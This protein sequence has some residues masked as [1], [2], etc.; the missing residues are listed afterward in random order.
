MNKP[1]PFTYDEFKSIAEELYHEGKMSLEEYQIC[2]ENNQDKNSFDG[3]LTTEQLKELRARLVS[4]KQIRKI[5]E[6]LMKYKDHLS[7]YT[8]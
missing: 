7:D 6:Y 1:N 4:E 3:K 2:L 5:E 8:D